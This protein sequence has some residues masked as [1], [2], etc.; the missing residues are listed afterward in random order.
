M[1]QPF[2][3]TEDRNARHP[4]DE[5]R[6]LHSRTD[7]ELAAAYAE[8]AAELKRSFRRDVKREEFTCHECAIVRECIVA[9]DIYNT[10]GDCLMDK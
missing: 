10:H 5:W 9:F 2:P 1:K 7:E 8:T 4:D 6:F 3:V